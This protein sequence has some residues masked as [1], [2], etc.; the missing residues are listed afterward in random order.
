VYRGG[1]TAGVGQ[2][3]PLLEANSPNEFAGRLQMWGRTGDSQGRLLDELEVKQAEMDVLEQK[4]E[5]ARVAAE[6]ARAEAEAARVE[7]EAQHAIAEQMRAEAEAAEAQAQA[8][9]AAAAEA[10]LTA[11]SLAAQAQQAV[12]TA[13]V[14][15]AATAQQATTA[16]QAAVQMQAA[17]DRYLAEERA[18]LERERR[19]G[20]P[21]VTFGPAGAGCQNPYPETRGGYRNGCIPLSALSKLTFYHAHYLRSDAA[22]AFNR[23]NGAFQ[24]AFGVPISVTDSYRSYPQQVALKK[25][26]PRLAATPGRSNHG[27]GVA[28]DLGGGINS[29]GTATHQW[30]RANAPAFGWVLPGWAQQGGSKPEAWH[31][32]YVG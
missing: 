19:A 31:W 9:R 20:I 15:Q 29:F 14:Q 24:A 6:A 21:S 22:A 3:I 17:R 4:V 32:E 13:T 27:W 5:E 28:V 23:L 2:L 18:R 30:M 25:Q 26:K 1:Y 8:A 16:A 7:A 12:Q 11:D 10:K